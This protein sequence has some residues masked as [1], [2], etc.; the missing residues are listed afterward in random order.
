MKVD[1]SYTHKYKHLLSTRDGTMGV[2]TI[3]KDPDGVHWTVILFNKKHGTTT[4][5]VYY[6]EDG[7]FLV[8]SGKPNDW[9]LVY[10]PDCM[11]GIMLQVME[12]EKI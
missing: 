5:N 4:R 7:S 11:G 12:E 8:S 6:R 10:D 1:L 3:A 9:D 2:K